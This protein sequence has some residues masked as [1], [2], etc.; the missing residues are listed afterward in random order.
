ML[1]PAIPDGRRKVPGQYQVPLTR[2]D[3]E[4]PPFFFRTVEVVVFAASSRSIWAYA[5]S[6]LT[7]GICE[8]TWRSFWDS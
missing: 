3:L 7:R 5:C 1:T 6:E 8:R 2:P 4:E